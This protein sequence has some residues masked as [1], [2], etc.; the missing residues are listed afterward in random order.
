MVGRELADYAVSYFES[1]AVSCLMRFNLIRMAFGAFASV[2]EASSATR[3]A[4]HWPRP[5]RVLPLREASVPWLKIVQ[6]CGVNA[7]TGVI[8]KRISS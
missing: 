1:F 4:L 8:D 2:F 7:S 6:S 3:P 5:P